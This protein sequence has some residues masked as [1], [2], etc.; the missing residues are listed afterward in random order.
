MSNWQHWQHH[1]HTNDEL[2]EIV[3][4]VY[5][6][7]IFTSLHLGANSYITGSVFMPYLFLGSKPSFP[8]KTENNQLN[9]KNKLNHIN[10][11]IEYEEETPIREEY[12]KNIGMLYEYNDKAGPQSINGYPIFMSMRILSKEDTIKFIDMYSKYVEM[13]KEFEKEW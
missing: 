7:K 3:R 5:D 9:R 4:D 1:F 8:S 10:E 6:C 12:F 2:K 11:I 13:R